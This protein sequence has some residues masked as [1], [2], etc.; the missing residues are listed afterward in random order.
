MLGPIL[1][2]L[3]LSFTASLYSKYY[4]YFKYYSYYLLENRSRGVII[5]ELISGHIASKWKIRTHCL[6]IK[7][8][9]YFPCVFLPLHF[10]PG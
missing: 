6:P 8:S 5:Y 2:T 4:F 1:S 9:S 10:A 3:H 7:L